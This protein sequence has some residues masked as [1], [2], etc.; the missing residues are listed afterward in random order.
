MVA[1]AESRLCEFM[2]ITVI[3]ADGLPVVR[4]GMQT[5]LAKH[6]EFQPAGEAGGGR[7]VLR[8]VRQSPSDVL[9]LDW[10]L[11][12]GTAPTVLEGIRRHW[13]RTRVVVTAK[14][15][16]QENVIEVLRKGAKAFILEQATEKTFVDA[17]RTVAK[18]E[19]YLGPPFSV[20]D[21]ETF[22]KRARE[23]ATDPLDSLTPRER[24]VFQMV[25]EGNTSAAVARFLHVN[26]R[27][28]EMHRAR[29]M[30][31]LDLGNQLEF[32]RFAANRGLLRLDES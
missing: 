30:Q 17:I 29:M 10:H 21:L 6:A 7:D 25:A 20:R 5:W 11:P 13:P 27:T 8:L 9:V 1:Q 2:A 24:E 26:V 16:R 15:S 3:V 28:V 14:C 4:Q 23:P 12:D 18:Q 19:Y 22:L 31:K 32:F